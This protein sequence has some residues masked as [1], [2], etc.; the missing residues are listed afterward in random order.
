M[1]TLSFANQSFGFENYEDELDLA[2]RC[3]IKMMDHYFSEL[4]LNN[5][6]VRNLLRYFDLDDIWFMD[7]VYATC[8]ASAEQQEQ[9]SLVLTKITE[10]MQRVSELDHRMYHLIHRDYIDLLQRILTQEEPAEVI[11]DYMRFYSST[12]IPRIIRGEIRVI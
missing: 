5:N 3:F 8:I 9:I 2:F 1:Y 10:E 4:K 12:D 11:Q 6:G 7:V